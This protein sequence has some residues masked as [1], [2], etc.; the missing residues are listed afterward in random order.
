[1]KV[2][3]TISEKDAKAARKNDGNATMREQLA[4]S[5]EAYTAQLIDEL[6]TLPPTY[7]YTGW[8]ES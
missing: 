2:M 6:G 8:N 4:A 5:E 3:Q 7:I 1:M